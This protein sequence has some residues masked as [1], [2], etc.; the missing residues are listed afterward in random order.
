MNVRSRTR[1]EASRHERAQP[2]RRRGTRGM[3]V[4]SRTGEEA[5]AACVRSRTGDEALAA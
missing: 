2:H 5:P 3:N 4:P 1:D